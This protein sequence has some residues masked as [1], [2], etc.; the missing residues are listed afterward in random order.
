MINTKET[1][2]ILQVEGLKK[3]YPIRGGFF[4]KTEK[5]VKAVDDI[6]FSLYEGKTIGLVGESGCGK[7]TAGKCI[8]RIHEPTAGRILY[9][10]DD[11]LK[12]SRK[13]MAKKQRELQMVFQDPSASIDPRQQV[14]NV[15]R[16]AYVG[17]GL[18][19][20]KSEI[21]DKVNELV[22]MVGLSRELKDRYPHELSGG[23]LQRLAI[24]RA[25]ACSPKLIVCDEPISALDVS[26]QA[27]IINLFEDLQEKLSL[28][29]V[30]IA[31]DLSVV[32]HISD[33]IAVM[34]LGKIVE[35]LHSD[36]LYKNA[37]HPYT[38]TLLSAVPIIDY[39]AEK[40]RDRTVL[41]GELP[42]P[43]N[44][45]SGCP[46]HTRCPYASER[47]K[48]DAPELKA[49]ADGHFVACHLMDK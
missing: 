21:D 43:I 40:K 48:S 24:A 26:I 22:E 49:I 35:I 28:S 46:F 37:A 2:P 45:P 8:L 39:Y 41:A 6:S 11:L 20:Y 38:Q 47:C 27:Q 31:H 13:E 23:Q 9:R 15:V 3:Y 14:G 10:G 19:H 12:L 7:T 5:S 17:D 25:L 34:Y 29:Y 1:L 16:E 18:P 32:K 44:R 30:F 36:D 42:S 33:E 4:S